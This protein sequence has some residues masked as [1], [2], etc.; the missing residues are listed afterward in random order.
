MLLCYLLTRCL[1]FF[2]IWRPRLKCTHLFEYRLILQPETMLVCSPFFFIF[3]YLSGFCSKS[4]LLN[5]T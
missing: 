5:K 3:L 4:V 2:V 1:S